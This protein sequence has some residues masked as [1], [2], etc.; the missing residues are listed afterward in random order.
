MWAKKSVYN[1]L[2][3]DLNTVLYRHDYIIV[4]IDIKFS[5]TQLQHKL[6]EFGVEVCF[7]L[8]GILLTDVHFKK[9]CH[10]CNATSHS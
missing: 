10:C 8:F 7:V 4:L 3:L 9:S 1:H 5:T 2:S 6:K